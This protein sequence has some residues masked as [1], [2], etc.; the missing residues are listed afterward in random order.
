VWPGKP[1]TPKSDLAVLANV[2]RPVK[3]ASLAKM[4]AM[5][6][7]AMMARKEA[8]A[9]MPI[10]KKNCCQFHLN[11]NAWPNLVHLVQ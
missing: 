10:N 2:D 4:V 1:L 6:K 11:A 9:K 8:Q 5:D 7:T 3:P